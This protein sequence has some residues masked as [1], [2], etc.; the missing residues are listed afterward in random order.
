M[1]EEERLRN[2]DE[3]IERMKLDDLEDSPKMAPRDW[4]RSRKVTPQLV[5]YWIRT[6]KIKAE[7]CLCGRKVIDV[8]EADAYN[9][10]RLAKH[11]GQ[12]SDSKA[13]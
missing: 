13:D 12:G 2:I 11:E 9:Q 3:Y 4:A 5:Y 1:D 10:E 7:T 6:K 8:V